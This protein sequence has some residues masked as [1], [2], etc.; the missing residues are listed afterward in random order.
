MGLYI[1]GILALIWF[2]M[3]QMMNTWPTL[4]SAVLGSIDAAN[5][6]FLERGWSL[7]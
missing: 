3:V 6:W 5:S 4:F 7:P 2:V 1:A